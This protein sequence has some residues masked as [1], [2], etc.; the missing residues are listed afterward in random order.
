D[1]GEVALH[2][3]VE[4]APLG[5]ERVVDARTAQARGCLDLGDG[6]ILEPRRPEQGAGGAD[7][8]LAVEALRARHAAPCIWNDLSSIV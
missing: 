6:G 3:L 1:L 5:A 2:G 7:G 4:Q 8:R